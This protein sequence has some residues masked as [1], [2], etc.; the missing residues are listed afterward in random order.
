TLTERI[1]GLATEVHR[2]TGPGLLESVYAA[3]L[4]CE[5]EHAGI[6]LSRQV[7]IPVTSKGMSIPLGFR[8]DIL[9][10]CI[11][12]LEIKAVPALLP[13]HDAQLQTYLRMS[14]IPIGLLLN[15]HAVRLKDGLRRACGAL[16][17]ETTRLSGPWWPSRFSVLR[18]P[19][20]T[21]TRTP[22]GW[23]RPPNGQCEPASTPRDSVRTAMKGRTRRHDMTPREFG[24]PTGCTNRQPAPRLP[25]RSCTSPAFR[26]G[27]SAIPNRRSRLAAPAPLRPD[28]RS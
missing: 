2:K 8:A 10:D 6:P 15:F 9:V 27:S 26:T 20:L 14:S 1:I 23:P 25:R 11:V 3:C 19:D 4:C 28:H 18:I 7:S 17:V 16:S 21:A 22:N 24:P 13:A 12:I 5:L